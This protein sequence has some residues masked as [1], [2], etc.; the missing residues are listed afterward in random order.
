MLIDD[1]RSQQV[2]LNEVMSSNNT[3]VVDEDGDYSDWI[4][5]YNPGDHPISLDGY[6]LSDDYDTPF[7]WVFPVMTLD[8][9]EYL[10]IWAS[11]K[12]RTSPEGQLH[13]N[14]AIQAA[15]EE[16][17]LTHPNGERIDELEPT[18][19]P[20]DFSIGRKPD[21]TGDWLFFDNPTPGWSNS[22]EPLG[23]ILEPPVFS[24]DPGFYREE[25]ELQI[26]HP[27]ED[28]IIYYTL[29]GSKPTVNSLV[30]DGPIT[31]RDRNSEPNGISTIPTNYLEDFRKSVP[32]RTTIKKGTVIRIL[33]VK[34]GFEPET[35]T[36]SYFVSPLGLNNHQLPV[37]SIS[38]DNKNLFD[39]E[40]GILVPGNRYEEGDP[41]TGNYYG[42]GIGWERE[43]SFEFFEESGE[44][45]FGQN[46][47]IRIHGGFTRRFTQKSFRIYARNE[48]GK[49]RMDYPIFPDQP[50]DSYKRLIIRNSGNDQAFSML[51]DA[52]AHRLVSHFNMDTQAYRPAIVYING[53]YW[54]LHNIRERLDK[55][56]LERKYG[57]DPERLDILTRLWEVVEGSNQQFAALLTVIKDRNLGHNPHYEYVKTRMDIDNYL[58]YFSAQIFFANTDWP[59]SN[60][61]FWRL[62]TSYN[63]EAPKGHD[64]RWRWMF[65]DLDYTLGLVQDPDY[66]ML[67]WVTQEFG[68]DGQDWPNQVFRNLLENESFR[69]DF[70]NRMADHLN[71]A[72]LPDRMVRIITEMKEVIEPEMH[73]FGNRWRY[74]QSVDIW[75]N[76]INKLIDWSQQRYVNHWQN[77]LD[78]FNISS[79]ENITLTVNDDSRGYIK[80]NS[81]DILPDT[82]GIPQNPYPWTGTYF[83]G[84]PVTLSA[85][86]QGE[87][88]FSHWEIDNQ[89]FTAPTLTLLADTTE[90]IQLFLE[91]VTTSEPEPFFLTE[92][93]YLFEDFSAD[94]PRGEYPE[95]MRFVY[96][97][98]SDPT[99]EADVAGFTTGSYNL[100]S[101][102]RINGLGENGFSFINTSNPD[103]NPGYPGG[104]LGGAILYLNTVERSNIE[105]EWNAGTMQPNSRIYNIRLQYRVGAEGVFK[106]VLDESG[107]PVEYKRNEEMGHEESMV[108]VILPTEAEDQPHVE[109]LWRYY[110]SGES[111]DEESGQRSQLHIS[112]ISVTS[113]PLGFVENPEP[114]E[115]E[116]PVPNEFKLYQN[117][118]NPF[119]PTS[120]IQ[121]D[122]PKDQHVKLEIYSVSGQF[123]KTVID[124][125]VQAGRHSLII[126]ASGLASGV[127]LYR[128]TTN[129]FTET[130]RM[131]AIK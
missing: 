14:F 106:N 118:P 60:I 108:P 22:T 6:G 3:F 94:T 67:G 123:I 103:G 42:R 28:V 115:P 53:E 11:N 33:T 96:M 119:H 90:S 80:L 110:Y 112:K 87:Y 127:Y 88:V 75:N 104:K 102:T 51:R 85:A 131:S 86:P 117:Y 69:I 82:P 24:H 89:I 114:P 84:I 81:I 40:I 113:K 9:G 5:L 47:G 45:A 21:G 70:I 25:F 46:V 4:E 38:T 126:D 129:E 39:D 120:T 10:I 18:E 2:R 98:D 105:I 68:K 19:I 95:A 66:D 12:D 27:Q 92:E 8:A 30:Y 36:N 71:T 99:L 101:R 130:L 16:V 41:E 111:V 35:S 93:D 34:Q 58:D 43:A 52:I 79:T 109:V 107:E 91:E 121:Y 23:G 124:R 56:Y 61:D 122:L 26:S 49:S 32:P 31:V 7:K 100:S 13:T 83:S 17:I 57:V 73:D 20:T 97:S 64:G 62:R 29:D 59:H 78:H 77:I 116:P 1:G 74:P 128:I 44:F 54:G 48:Y 50:Y 76:T 63:P 125:P 55:H 72:F 37:I 65:Y 15:G